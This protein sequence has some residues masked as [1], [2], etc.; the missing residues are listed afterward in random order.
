MGDSQGFSRKSAV[1]L[2][3]VGELPYACRANNPLLVFHDAFT[4]VRLS[5]LRTAGDCLPG[6]MMQAFLG[7]KGIHG[8]GGRGGVPPGMGGIGWGTEIGAGGT[9]VPLNRARISSAENNPWVAAIRS[10]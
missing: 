9:M 7:G 10:R 2:F 3:R 4:A 6:G 8:L 1:E 5:A